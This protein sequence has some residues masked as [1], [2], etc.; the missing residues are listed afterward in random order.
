MRITELAHGD[1]SK[2][3]VLV[4][5][6][7]APVTTVGFGGGVEA[8]QRLRTDEDTGVASERIEVAPRASFEIG[9]RNLFGTKR[10]VNLFTSASLHPESVSSGGTPSLSTAG[11]P[12]F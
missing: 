11:G 3:D 2:R 9:R 8:G 4:S 10:S 12:G 7:E 6:E 5:V 1:E